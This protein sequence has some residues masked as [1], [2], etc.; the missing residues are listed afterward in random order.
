MPQLDVFN[1]DAF[2]LHTLTDTINSLPHKPGRLGALGLF[3]E[4]GVSTT[5]INVESKDGRLTLVQTSQRGGPAADPVGQ[6]KRGLRTFNMQHLERDSTVQ[7]GEI[8]GVRAFGQENVLQT[9]QDIVNERLQEIKDAMEVTHEY[10]RVGAL[11][12]LILDADGSTI[13]N[14][15]TEFGVAQQTYDFELTDDGLDVRAAIIAAKRLSEGVLGGRMVNGYRAF[16][17]SDFFD[18]LVGHPVVAESF[19]YQEGQVLREDL[20]DGFTYGGVVWEEYRGSVSKPDSVGGGTATFIDAD[21]A[22]LVPNAEI[23]VTRFA[24]ADYEET[25]NTIGLPYYAKQVPDVSGKNKYRLVTA[26]SNPIHLN[27][28][29]RAVI[30]LTHS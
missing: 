8:Q 15:F 25:V 24:P 5:S 20:R 13:Y 12:G 1:G 18:A 21:Q 4:R 16:C 17:G 22:F 28:R 9:V 3:K 29:P 11:Q 7:A 23:F 19:K 6:N 27:L 26:Q 2:S 30:K 14:L 10:H